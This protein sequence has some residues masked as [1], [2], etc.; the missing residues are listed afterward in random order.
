MIAAQVQ[1]VVDPAPDAEIESAK[2]RNDGCAGDIIFCEYDTVRAC[3]AWLRNTDH[4]DR[5]GVPHC[6][7]L[8]QC[9][10]HEAPDIN[11]VS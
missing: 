3:V 10:R 11:H 1:A 4:H 5:C 8:Q 7:M 2:L 6:S 9:L